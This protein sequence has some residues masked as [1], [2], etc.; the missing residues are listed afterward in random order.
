MKKPPKHQEPGRPVSAAVINAAADEA[1]RAGSLAL[2]GMMSAMNGPAGILAT[3]KRDSGFLVV[4]TVA[5]DARSG[6]ACDF[7]DCPLCTWDGE[8]FATNAESITQRIY[9]FWPSAIPGNRTGV[10]VWIFSAWWMLTWNCTE[11]AAP[12]LPPTPPPE[13]DSTPYFAPTYFPESYFGGL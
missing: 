8:N 13:D 5:I 2:G 9:N 6:N 3:T 12:P 7:G 10:A 4:K 1:A 11:N